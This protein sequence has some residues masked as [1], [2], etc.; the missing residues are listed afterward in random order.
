MTNT[1]WAAIVRERLAPL[2]GEPPDAEF[3]DELAAHLAQVYEESRRDG[4]S[5][6]ES[7]QSALGLLTPSSPWVDAARERAAAHRAR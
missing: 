2:L 7:R 3:V 4:R 1:R 6:D 5:E